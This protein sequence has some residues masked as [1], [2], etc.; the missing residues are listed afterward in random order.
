MRDQH[1]VTVFVEVKVVDGI[2]DVG[3]VITVKKRFAL[4]RTIRWYQHK[5]GVD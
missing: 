1:G 4:Q 5:V 2:D 3:G